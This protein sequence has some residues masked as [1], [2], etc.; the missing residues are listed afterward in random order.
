MAGELLAHPKLT[1][2]YVRLSSHGVVRLA[3]YGL[4]LSFKALIP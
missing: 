3:K 1:L 4:G 2:R